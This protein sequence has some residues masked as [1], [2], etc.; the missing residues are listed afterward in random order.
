MAGHASDDPASAKPRTDQALMMVHRSVGL[1]GL[2]PAA[3]TP[4]WPGP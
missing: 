2:E 3:L 1:T 4:K